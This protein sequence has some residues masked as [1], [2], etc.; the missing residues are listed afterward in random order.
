[1]G[2]INYS[3]GGAHLWCPVRSWAIRCLAMLGCVVGY[4]S[5]T[6]YCICMY[7]YVGMTRNGAPFSYH[8]KWVS[9]VRNTDVCLAMNWTLYNVFSFRTIKCLQIAVFVLWWRLGIWSTYI[10]ALALKDCRY[11]KDQIKTKAMIFNLW[12][13][14]LILLKNSKWWF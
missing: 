9:N 4:N 14:V 11:N 6:S 8:V 5:P 7:K 13:S 2:L 3:G 12:F 10:M 1:M